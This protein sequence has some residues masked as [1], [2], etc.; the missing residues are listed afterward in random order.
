MSVVVDVVAPARRRPRHSTLLMAGAAFAVMAGVL[1]MHS[2]PMVHS[3]GGHM[4]STGSMTEHSTPAVSGISQIVEKCAANC[5]GHAGM[6]MCMAVITIASALIF[7]RRLLKHH[8][9]GPSRRWGV[10]P[11]GRHASRAPPW[12]TP[13]L[14]KLSILRI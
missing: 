10:G 8:T 6:A 13:T 12:V 7:V 11:L 9:A 4:T 5:S 14:E 3:P 2:V 1:L